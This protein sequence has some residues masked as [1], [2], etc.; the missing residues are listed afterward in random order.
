MLNFSLSLMSEVWHLFQCRWMIKL[1]EAVAVAEAELPCVAALHQPYRSRQLGTSDRGYPLRFP[2]RFNAH[3]LS[4]VMKVRAAEY[5]SCRC[6]SCAC[7]CIT[8][9]CTDGR[10]RS[11]RVRDGVL[12]MK[13]ADALNSCRTMRCHSVPHQQSYNL[14]SRFPLVLRKPNFTVWTARSEA[15][16]LE[17]W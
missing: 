3:A 6:L 14:S 8:V 11:K 17:G 9:S 1:T 2:L 13:A 15:P 10:S 16:L 12:S 4:P 5:V 7:F